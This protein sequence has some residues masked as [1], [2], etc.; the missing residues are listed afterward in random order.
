MGMDL[1]D[2]VRA[3]QTALEEDTTLERP[4]YTWCLA[5]VKE[6]LPLVNAALARDGVWH[7]ARKEKQAE[8]VRRLVE[9]I[10]PKARRAT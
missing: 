6:H 7:G 1:K 3:V 2:Y 5:K 4:K 8:V 9:A 10:K